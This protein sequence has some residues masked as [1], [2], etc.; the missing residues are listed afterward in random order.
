[1]YNEDEFYSNLA[2]FDQEINALR[3]AL[4][5]KVKK[6]FLDEMEAL[7]KAVKELSHVNSR[8]TEIKAE[9][10]QKMM[11][12][13]QEKVNAKKEA[14]KMRLSELMQDYKFVLYRPTYHYETG[15]KCNLCDEYG[16]IKLTTPGG[17]EVTTECDCNVRISSI[18]PSKQVLY[19]FSFDHWNNTVRAWY[20]LN[21]YSL[22]DNDE[23]QLDYQVKTF[24]KNLYKG[25]DYEEL[26]YN[27][28]FFE[29]L[30]ECQK[31]CNW[32]NKK[33]KEK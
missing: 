26:N 21:N 33:K 3:K 25:E 19:S 11:E 31:Y 1:M 8:W 2:E 9:H 16:N 22:K 18:I 7:R 27:E 28:I 15:P 32:Y 6:E 24:M 29:T 5:E 23:F 12:L 14:R 10:R 20:V 13:E 4:K 30:E 17:R